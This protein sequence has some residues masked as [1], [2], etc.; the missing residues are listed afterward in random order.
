MVC[1][2]GLDAGLW[3]AERKAAPFL[4]GLAGRGLELGLEGGPSAPGAWPWRGG[5]LWSGLDAAGLPC[6]LVN[7]PGLWPAPAV[8]GYVLARPPAGRAAAAGPAAHPPELAGDLGDY[9][10]PLRA[11]ARPGR[12]SQPRRDTLFARAAA[13]ARIRY[14]HARRLCKWRPPAVAGVGFGG[15]AQLRRLWPGLD[16]PRHGQ[17]LAQLDRYVSRLARRLEPRALVIAGWG[18]GAGLGLAAWPGCS[19]RAGRA[20]WPEVVEAVAH[21]AGAAGG[22]P[23]GGAL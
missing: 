1:L 18:E 4:A 10:A 20:E 16:S 14:E 22:E 15:L 3:A 7:L 6:G 19:P 2:P 9:P 12:L 17:L 5:T 23:F 13:T 8:S 21:L 11:P